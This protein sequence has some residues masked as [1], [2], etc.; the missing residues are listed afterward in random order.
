MDFAVFCVHSGPPTSTLG[1]QFPATSM[2]LL[3]GCFV[4]ALPWSATSLS[5]KSYSSV[6]PSIV[7]VCR[8]ILPCIPKSPWCGSGKSALLHY[9][10]QVLYGSNAQWCNL[11]PLPVTLLLRNTRGE[12]FLASQSL[13]QSSFDRDEILQPGPMEACLE[14]SFRIIGLGVCEADAMGLPSV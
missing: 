2:A 5:A 14:G 8:H 11:D 12:R 1:M 7:H 3:S 4:H 13:L 10:M 9:W 6:F